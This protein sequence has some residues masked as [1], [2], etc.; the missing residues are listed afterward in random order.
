LLSVLQQGHESFAD[1]ALAMSTISEAFEDLKNPLL[2]L[3][4]LGRVDRLALVATKADHITADQLNNLV[5]LLRDMIG[6]PFIQA[7]ARQSGLFAVASVRSTTQATRKWQDVALPFLHGVPEGRGT[8]AIEVRPG[9]IP[10]EIPDSAQWDALEFNIRQFA[11][12]RL[13][14][15]YERPLPHINLDKVLQFLIA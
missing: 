11:P 14:A 1:L 3:L 7:N 6:E 5:G 10:G 8:D 15:P 4:P 2:K 9:V 12:P 13:G